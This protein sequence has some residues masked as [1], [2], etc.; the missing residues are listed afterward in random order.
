MLPT[1]LKWILLCMITSIIVY[2]FGPNLHDSCM[3]LDFCCLY[4]CLHFLYIPLS[5]IKM[6][7]R[8]D[9][10]KIFCQLEISDRDVTKWRQGWDSSALPRPSPQARKTGRCMQGVSNIFYWRTASP[11]SLRSCIYSL[12]WWEIRRSGC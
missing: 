11:R 7:L 8:S 10:I 6:L 9:I 4:M 5:C 12:W 3:A 1:L 2:L